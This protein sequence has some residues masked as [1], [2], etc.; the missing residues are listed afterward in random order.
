MLW[1][2]LLARIYEVLPLLSPSR[3]YLRSAPV[4]RRDTF[5]AIRHGVQPARVRVR[6]VLAPG[7]GVLSRVPAYTLPDLVLTASVRLLRRPGRWLAE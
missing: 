4:S 7:L 5:S 3:S 6:S 2:Q 1:A